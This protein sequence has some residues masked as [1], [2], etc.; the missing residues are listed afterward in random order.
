MRI[1]S[2]RLAVLAGLALAALAG[3]AVAQ[4]PVAD[5]PAEKPAAK[6]VRSI[7]YVSILGD[8]GRQRHYET[9]AIPLLFNRACFGWRMYLGGPNRTVTLTEVLT[10]SQPAEQVIA[11]PE[12]EV[13]ADKTRATTKMREVV[14]DG[15]L[16]RSWC[17][18]PGDPPGIYTY[19]ISIDGEP[20][21]EFVFCAIEMPDQNT[22]IDPRDLN[23]PNK[24][25]SVNARP[26]APRKA[27]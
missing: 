9:N 11:G 16:Q 22:N 26:F 7:P 3:V 21:G 4:T 13:S 24:F 25:N 2:L 14:Q 10:T 8:D 1:L 17:I 5:K 23:C 20:R 19:D 18:I 12:T 15:V 27:S 6:P